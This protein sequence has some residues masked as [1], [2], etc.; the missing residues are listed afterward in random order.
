MAKN[1]KEYSSLVALR[2]AL[3]S[4]KS[5]QERKNETQKK[6]NEMRFSMEAPE[7]KRIVVSAHEDKIR[8]DFAEPTLKKARAEARERDRG[9]T[10]ARNFFLIVL[11]IAIIALGVFLGYKLGAWSF[12]SSLNAIVD[13]SENVGSAEA[14]GVYLFALTFVLAG[15]S[16]LLFGYG[17]DQGMPAI[18]TFGVIFA[19]GA[20]ASL[21]ASFANFYSS[22]EGFFYGV[23]LFIASFFMIGDFIVTLFKILV[24][25][26]VAG[27]L[28]IGGVRLIYWVSQ[29]SEEV[30]TYEAPV[31]DFS[32]IE[33]T[34]EF[35]KALELDRK[36]TQEA[37]AK[38]RKDYEKEHEIFT[39]Q[40]GVYRDAIGKYNS[41]IADCD[42]AINSAT[43]LTATYRNLDMVN[44]IIYYIDSHRADNIKEAVNEYTRDKQNAERNKQI[45]VLEKKLREQI[46]ENKRLRNTVA[47][48][49]SE[50]ERK[51][52]Q[53]E[54]AEEERFEQLQDKLDVMREERWEQTRS[55]ERE[56]SDSADMIYWQLYRK[57]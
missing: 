33:K 49:R 31:I 28:I 3:L 54:R 42:K 32:E 57:L 29:E 16:M 25:A 23:L 38:Y 27:G 40:Q 35:K 4:K 8:N 55:I 18:T 46:A 30:N 13:P 47:E 36:A 39:A 7:Q 52:E 44:T 6:L 24:A 53:A 56:I 17:V 50:Y 19:I 26:A 2:G 20:V 21:I 5:A 12:N 11:S 1:E 48:F 22:S 43:F 51:L 45:A 37:K 15:I 41:I 34:E 9:L 14:I 10:G